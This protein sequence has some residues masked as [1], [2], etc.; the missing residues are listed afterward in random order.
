MKDFIDL[1]LNKAKKDKTQ[2]VYF[3][4]WMEERDYKNSK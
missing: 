3:Q 1:Q 2:F 4:P